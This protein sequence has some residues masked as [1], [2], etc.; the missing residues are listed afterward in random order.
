MH[1]TG[2]ILN[3]ELVPWRHHFK[4]G[5]TDQKQLLDQDEGFADPWFKIKNH[6]KGV[7][8]HWPW[9]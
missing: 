1:K 9:I 4:P 6:I 8:I 2:L 5:C 7:I 3:S